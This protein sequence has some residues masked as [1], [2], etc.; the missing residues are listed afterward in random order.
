MSAYTGLDELRADLEAAGWRIYRTG[1][2][3]VNVCNWYAVEP[4]LK[5][6]RPDCACNDKPPVVI[7]QPY[8]YEPMNHRACDVELRGQLPNTKDWV[9]FRVYGIDP[10]SVLST[11][12]TYYRI[13]ASAW[14]AAAEGVSA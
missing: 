12:P 4:T 3:S 7:V 11:Y 2:D 13:L 10:A 6:A 8:L 9:S 5:A 1:T 14:E